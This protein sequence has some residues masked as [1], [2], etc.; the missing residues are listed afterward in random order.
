MKRL[1]LKIGDL[2]VDRFANRIFKV[3]DIRI[4]TEVKEPS[5]R[6]TKRT[7][8]KLVSLDNNREMWSKTTG[9]TKLTPEQVDDV[10]KN[11]IIYKKDLK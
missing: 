4:E 2:V 3:G 9:L 7:Y 8:Y 10:N 5:M 1:V 6:E 11:G